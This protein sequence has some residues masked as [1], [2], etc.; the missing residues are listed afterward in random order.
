MLTCFVLAGQI[1]LSSPTE[2]TI[3]FPEGVGVQIRPDTRAY[4]T[5]RF[6][7][8][9]Q[10]EA[11]EERSLSVPYAEVVEALSDCETD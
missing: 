3:V 1:M 10:S 6:F 2:Q 7:G 4:T 11:S 8:G 5:I 9:L